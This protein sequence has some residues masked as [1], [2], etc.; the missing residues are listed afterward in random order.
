MPQTRRRPAGTGRGGADRIV[1][2]GHTYHTPAAY[3]PP[4]PIDTAR[5]AAKTAIIDA[6]LIGAVD[7][8][9]VYTVLRLLDLEAA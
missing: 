9:R 5:A 8:T 4:H 3:P 7:A 1:R 6:A 2:A